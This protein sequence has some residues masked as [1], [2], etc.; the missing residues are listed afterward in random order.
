MT[1]KRRGALSA[2]L[3]TTLAASL[4]GFALAQ[5]GTAGW[6]A[7]PL[8][9]VVPYPPGGSSDI[10]ARAI[11][12]PLSEALKQPVIVENKPGANGNLG[13]D[14]VAKSAPDG[15]TLLLCDVGALAISP[16]VYTR[17]SFDPSKDLRGVT[18]LAYS[19]HLLVVH[20][21]VKANNLKELV[22]LSKTSELNFAV[23]ATG[24]APHLA[25]VALERASGAKWTYVPYKGGVQ[26]VQDTVSGQTQVLM[27]GML[28]TLPQV[29]GGRLKVLGV[30]KAT[31]MP[32]IGDVP[33]I[34]EQGVP[35]YESGTWQ[36]VR[37]ARGTP[38]AIVQRLNK[39][40]IAVIRTADIRSRLAG[41]GAEVVTMTPAEEERFFD[42][43]R[44]RW[45]K[46]VAD[47]SIKLD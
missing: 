5:A 24:S 10:I 21:S 22:A 39:E 32:L 19:P 9:I 28:A 47:A 18:M 44:A 38:E 13:A 35:G 8:R 2:A 45:A 16:S 43:E 27:N 31:R 11:S 20:P 36:G 3:A 33:T 37:V 1:I 26:A 34:A 12:Q 7:K 15:Y 4:P 46:V 30:S 17:L 40:L 6:P 41:Q 42:K 14:F 23:T 29:Q 25:G